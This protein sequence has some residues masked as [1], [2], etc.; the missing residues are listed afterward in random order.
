MMMRA[1][2][3]LCLAVTLSSCAVKE[4]PDAAEVRAQALPQST[5]IPPAYRE[6]ADTATGAVTEGWLASFHDSRLNALVREAI[7]HNLNLHAAVAN[8]DAAAGLATQAG[9][10]LKPVVAAGGKANRF[11]AGGLKQLT[12]TGAAVNM[13]WEL[14]LWG[15]VR[16]QSKAG[17]AAFEAA[18]YQLAWIYQSVAAQTVKSWFLLSE[19]RQQLKLAEDALKLYQ[20]TLKLVQSQYRQGRV[21][22]GDVALARANVAR[23]EAQVRQARGAR[24]QAA[25]ALELLLG[26]YPAGAMAGAERFEMELPPVPA[27]LPSELLERRPDLK[28]AEHA[29]AAQFFKV[30]SAKAA[31]LPRVALTAGG[32]T[33]SNQLANLLNLGS[34]FWSVGSN[35]MLPLYTGGALKAQVDIESAQ[36]QAALANYGQKALKAFAEV[37]QGLANERLLRERENYLRA[38]VRESATALRVAQKQFEV[39]KVSLLSVLQQQGLLISAKVALTNIQDQ[40]L[41]QRVD[42]YLAL[43]GGFDAPAGESKQ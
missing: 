42:L 16:A 6:A 17:Q 29:I 27:G 33:S 7:A 28:A 8:V 21:T 24:Q 9:A 15:R 12:Q 13:S 18:Q 20:Q 10:E 40:R 41:Q 2:I 35:F 36:F 32:G 4:A 26:R 14:D 22:E 25:R 1:L 11:D 38:A 5:A 30:E 39:G 34:N 37:E 23:G 31:R 43:G 19:A 3:L